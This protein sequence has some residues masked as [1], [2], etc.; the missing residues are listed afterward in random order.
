MFWTQSSHVLA[1]FISYFGFK[2]LIS[3]LLINI[4]TPKELTLGHTE[5]AAQDVFFKEISKR[6]HEIL[7]KLSLRTENHMF[8]DVIR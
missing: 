8:S 2:D 3:T 6:F 1:F 7:R 5:T 4:E